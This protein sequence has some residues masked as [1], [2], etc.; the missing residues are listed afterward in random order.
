MCH[1]YPDRSCRPRG[2]FFNSFFLLII[3]FGCQDV[4]LNVAAGLADLNFFIH[5]LIHFFVGVRMLS[6]PKP[7]ASRI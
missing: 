6:L 7:Q 3:F 1:A 2:F 4:I 5:F